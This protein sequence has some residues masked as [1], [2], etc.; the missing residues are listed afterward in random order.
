[1]SYLCLFKNGRIAKNAET[2]FYFV[3]KWNISTKNVFNFLKYNI[4]EWNYKVLSQKVRLELIL[5]YNTMFKNLKKNEIK[6]SVF[7]W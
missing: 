7:A 3:Y 5:G 2:N 6:Q 4:I 1:M